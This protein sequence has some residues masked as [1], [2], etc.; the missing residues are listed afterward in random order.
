MKRTRCQTRRCQTRRNRINI[1]KGGKRKRSLTAKHTT[2]GK[3]SQYGGKTARPSVAGSKAPVCSM[4]RKEEL[5][6]YSEDDLLK[7]RNHW[8][9]RHPDRKIE[10]N[11]PREIWEGLSQKLQSVCNT[12]A[13]WLRQR[14]IDSKTAKELMRNA[15]APEAPASW[16]KNPNEWLSSTDIEQVMQQFETAYPCFEFIGPSPIDYDKHIEYGECVWEELC[17][18]DLDSFVKRGKFKIG[19]IFNLDPH[20]KPGS[21]WVSLFV[22]LKKGYVFYFDSAGS[23]P[24]KEVKRLVKKIIEQA[25][26]LDISLEY[27]END[28]DHQKGDNECGMYSLYAIAAQLRDSKLPSAFL[29][30]GEITDKSMNEMRRKFFNRSGTL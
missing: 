19:I 7:L 30:G 8:N 27:I 1:A 11:D 13:C 18:F 16:L 9:S 21:H 10:S 6:C 24:P 23:K 17:K 20:Y 3:L 15:F 12:E 26:K 4:G 22:N 28:R 2:R 25:S 5:S 29:T 14:F